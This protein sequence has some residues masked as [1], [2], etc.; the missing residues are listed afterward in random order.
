VLYQIAQTN[1][2]LG[3][4]ATLLDPFEHRRGVAILVQRIGDCS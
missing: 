2:L 4:A 1:E 3:T